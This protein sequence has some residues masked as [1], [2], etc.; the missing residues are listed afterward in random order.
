[1]IREPVDEPV[2]AGLVHDVDPLV[3]QLRGL[4]QHLG[5][6]AR[7]QLAQLDHNRPEGDLQ[8]QRVRQ[9]EYLAEHDLDDDVLEG[10]LVL[11]RVA[12]ELGRALLPLLV[13]GEQDVSELL[14]YQPPLNAVL[15]GQDRALGTI[16]VVKHSTKSQKLVVIE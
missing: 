9:P 10:D 8:T 4:G 2:E 1:M 12:E 7:L 5:H 3:E 15:P 14:L 13:V 6:G 16:S 11:E